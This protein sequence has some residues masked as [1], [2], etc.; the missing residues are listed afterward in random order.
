MCSYIFQGYELL[1]SDGEVEVINVGDAEETPYHIKNNSLNL[2]IKAKNGI[3][4]VWDKKTG[5]SIKVPEQFQ[6]RLICFFF[7][8]FVYL[9]SFGILG[10]YRV[11]QL[12]ILE[13]G[14]NISVFRGI[15]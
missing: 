1:L 15:V 14:Q 13:C 12:A 4:L 3:I 6:V 10:L 2:I 5:L 9:G 8:Y 7:L 11:G